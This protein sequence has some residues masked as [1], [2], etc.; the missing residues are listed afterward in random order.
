MKQAILNEHRWLDLLERVSGG[1]VAPGAFV[2]LSEAY[3][4]P[5]RRYHNLG[6]IEHCLA[7]FDRAA[8]LAERPDEVEV[9][10]WLHDLVYDPRTGDN[11]EKGALLGRKILATAGTAELVMNRVEELILATKHGEPP[12]SPD[13]W[14][15]VD[16]DLS[17]LGQPSD[18]FDSYEHNIRLEAG[19][20][21]SGTPLN[22]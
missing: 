14:L 7:E 15:L 1:P 11:E 4:Q 10:I 21:G 3:A 2:L 16:I 8:G 17:I 22:F 6:H 20:A 13:A 9:A 12:V 18:V 19:E 5:H